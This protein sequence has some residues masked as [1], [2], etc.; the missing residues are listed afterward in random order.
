[1]PLCCVYS[2]LGGGGG[3]CG[4]SALFRIRTLDLRTR[5]WLRILLFWSVTYQMPAKNKFVKNLFCLL[6]S[7]GTGTFTSVFKDKKSLRSH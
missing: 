4:F 1:M 7:V 2:G 5:I 3:V 6:L